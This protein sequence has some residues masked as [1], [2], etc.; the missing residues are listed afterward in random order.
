MEYKGAGKLA[1][2]WAAFE[3]LMATFPEYVPTYLMA[4]GTLVALGRQGEAAVVFQKG[5]EVAARGG[6][7]H[8][9]KELESALSELSS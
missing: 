2:A 3:D 8:A 1:D 5:I 9:K 6:D 7:L 4:G